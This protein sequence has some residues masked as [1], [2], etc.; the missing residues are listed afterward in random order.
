MVESPSP[1]R[2]FQ[3]S[4]FDWILRVVIFVVF[5]F[6]GASKFKSNADAP[7]VVL[8]SQIGFGQWFRCFTGVLEI[9][10]A[11]LVLI[12]QTVTGGLTVLTSVMT[13]AVLIDMIVLRRPADA[14][15]PFAIL[16]AFLALWLHRRRA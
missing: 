16:C 15:V 3:S 7:W 13:G 10:G 9:A 2:K 6:L 1:E 14:F 12:P 11:F 8:F 5:L 4:L